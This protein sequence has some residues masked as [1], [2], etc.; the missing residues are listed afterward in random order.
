MF[1]SIVSLVINITF[2]LDTNVSIII[3]RFHVHYRFQNELLLKAQIEVAEKKGSMPEN[4]WTEFEA[5]AFKAITLWAR[6]NDNDS[7]NH[8]NIDDDNETSDGDSNNC[9]NIK[10]DKNNYNVN[11]NIKLESEPEPEP[12]LELKSKS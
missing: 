1:T 7:I 9:N 6:N 12:E 4:W 8:S 3:K 5:I 11:K 2:A 10:N